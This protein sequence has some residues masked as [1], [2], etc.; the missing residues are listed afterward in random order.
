MLKKFYPETDVFKKTAEYS[1]RVL[2]LSTQRV[3][4]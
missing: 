3:D 4:R 1:M 2:V